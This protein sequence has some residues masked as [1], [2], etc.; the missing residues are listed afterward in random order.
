MHPT[1]GAQGFQIL[2]HSLI[3]HI[4]KK[5][6]TGGKAIRSDARKKR[7]T[8]YGTRLY[9]YNSVLIDSIEPRGITATIMCRNC[10]RASDL[11]RRCKF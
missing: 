2:N 4:P 7:N 8:K 3:V 1:P 11:K 10:D 9:V 6:S 5:K